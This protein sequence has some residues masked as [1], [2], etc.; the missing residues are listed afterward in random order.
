MALQ[1]RKAGEADTEANMYAVSRVLHNRIQPNSG[2]PKLQ[3]C[4]TRDYISGIHYAAG[5]PVISENYNTYL[6][7]GMPVGAI[8]NPGIVALEAA[9][10]PSEDARYTRCYFFATDY[11]T[12]TTYFSETFAQH[13][14]I[15]RKYGIGMYG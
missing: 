10:S 12:M 14:A 13:E 1:I 11:D 4:S 9:L 7:E 6:R 8:N 15:C 3:L 5:N 2:Y